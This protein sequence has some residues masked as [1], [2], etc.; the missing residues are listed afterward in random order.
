MAY[1]V[2]LDRF[3]GPLDLLLQLIERQEIDIHDIPIARITEQYL[4]HLE[5]MRR[6]DLEVT[7]E[8]VVLAAQLIEIKARMLLPPEPRAQEEEAAEEPD[9]REELVRRLLEYRRYKEA[10][11]YL[12]QLAEQ[13]G[14]R[15]PRLAEAIEPLAGELSGLEGVTLEDLVRAFATVL[16]AARETPEVVVEP[17]EVTVAQ[18]MDAILRLLAAT[19][20]P[21]TFRACFSGR[22]TRLEVVVTFLALLEL[23]RQGRVRVRQDRAFGEIVLYPAE[24]VR[25]EPAGGEERG[26]RRGAG[27][28]RENGGETGAAP[29]AEEAA[30]GGTPA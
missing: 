15:Y 4:E 26:G 5:A 12:S 29:A 11:R 1:T 2:R 7:S 25:A 8:F 28:E 21:V 30:P 13:H 9:P 3:E 19:A 23:I 17:E 20:G 10:A 27:A 14:G 6:L 24:G 16:A 22:A 18:Q